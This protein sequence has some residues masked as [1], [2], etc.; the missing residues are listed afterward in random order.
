VKWEIEGFD[1]TKNAVA[2]ERVE[3]VYAF[4]KRDR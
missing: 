3:L 2:V 1:A 4:S